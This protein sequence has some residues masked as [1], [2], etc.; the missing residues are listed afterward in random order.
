MATVGDRLFTPALIALMV[1]DL[2]Y[3]TASGLLLG[4]TP[5][6]VTGPLESG[7]VGLGLVFGVFSAST[8]LLRPLVGRTADRSGRRRL[9]IG[10]EAAFAVL[11]ASHVLASE[12]W[13]LVLIRL[14]LGAAE[15]FAFVAGFAILADLAPPGRAGEALSWSS[16]ALYLGIA[17]GPPLGQALVHLGGFN[18]AWLAGTALALFATGLAAR[19]PE[20]MPAGSPPGDGA[21]LIHWGVIRPSL[22]L[23]SGVAATAAY[24]AFV[25]LYARDRGFEAWSVVPLVA[26]AVTLAGGALLLATPTAEAPASSP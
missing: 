25:G 20:T 14:L 11:I 6:F 4:V 16:V 1:S 26:S 17:L 2:A 10:G 22:G 3:F 24:L 5:F 9:L 8:L 19:I 12:L 13:V 18:A 23:F 7:N 21:P 15:A